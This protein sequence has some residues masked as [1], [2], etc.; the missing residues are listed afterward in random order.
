M[1]NL[2][3]HFMIALLIDMHAHDEVLRMFIMHSL[4]PF[5]L[6]VLEARP[7][8][9]SSALRAT[10]VR[11]HLWPFLEGLGPGRVPFS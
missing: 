4:R 10:D 3:A 5:R 1:L 6:C 2:R 7:P 8:F 9:G 11:M